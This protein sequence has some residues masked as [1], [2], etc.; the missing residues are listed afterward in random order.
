MTTE[1]FWIPTPFPGRFAI[2]ARPRGGDWLD[3]EMRGWRERG[4]D[5][6]V[7]MLT[8]EEIAEFDL[9]GETAAGAAQ[10]MRLVSFPVPD[11]DVPVSRAGFLDLVSEVTREL[12]ARRRVAIH[13]RQ[14]IG[15]SALVALAVLIAAGLDPQEAVDRVS[16]AR[17]RP[18]PETPAQRNWLDEFAAAT[19]SP[20][21]AV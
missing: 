12:T 20:S 17:G 8:P 3:D 18:V 10:G 1:L 4:I 19:D 7:S 9:V 6:I 2:A 15:R 5:V 11:R 14:G 21:T 16:A 13:C